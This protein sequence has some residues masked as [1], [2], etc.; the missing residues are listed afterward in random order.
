MQTPPFDLREFLT[1]T[2]PFKLKPLKADQKPLWGGMTAQH[3]VEHL[4]LILVST[5]VI[6][7]MA[8]AEPSEFQRGAL[9]M[10]YSSAPMP[11]HLENPIYKDGLPVFAHANLE[12]AKAKLVEKIALFC[13][14]Y[15]AKPNATYYHPFFS[16]LEFDGLLLFHYKHFTHHFTQFGLFPEKDPLY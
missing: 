12:V 6:S 15:D 13:K 4:E 11:R 14:V 7:Q 3:M 8:K 2:V 16:S 10:L 1:K 9:G 5:T